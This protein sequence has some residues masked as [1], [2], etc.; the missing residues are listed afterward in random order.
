M[1]QALTDHNLA[2]TE[3]FTLPR[4]GDP[5]T[6]VTLTSAAKDFLGWL[7]GTPDLS[8]ATKRAYRADFRQ[9][10]VAMSPFGEVLI[11]DLDERH[12]ETWKASMAGLEPTTIRRKLVA[13]SV[14]FDWARMQ[15]IVTVNPVDFVRKPKKRRKVMA[16]VPLEHYELLLAACRSTRDRAML[17]CLFWAGCRRQEVVDLDVGAL[18]LD[19]GTLFVKGKGQNERLLPVALNLRSLLADQLRGLGH[20]A[21]DEPLF[22]NRNGRRMSTKSLNSWF[23][24]IC[25]RAGLLAQGYTPHACRRG[26]AA[27]MHEQGFPNFAIQAYMGHEDP[28]TT[29][30]YVQAAAQGL[31]DRMD[32]SP[33]FGVEGAGTTSARGEVEALRETVDDLKHIVGQLLERLS[34]CVEEGVHPLHEALQFRD[35][36][37][38]HGDAVA[39]GEPAQ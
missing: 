21:P 31:R 9:F 19:R 28:K 25:R 33:L 13:L 23:R 14:F 20:R 10:V 12:I 7:E 17:G 35:D 18:D 1:P 38:H 16:T 5:P 24:V 32:S 11:T 22:P 27:L 34:P 39:H 4:L 6:D 26:I 2:V 37:S 36:V 29:A 30:G 8:P 3:Q 15:R